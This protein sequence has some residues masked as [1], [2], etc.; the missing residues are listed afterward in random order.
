LS[1]I[2]FLVFAAWLLNT[3][4]ASS[5]LAEGNRKEYAE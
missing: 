3:G 5:G 4:V 2:R 1:L